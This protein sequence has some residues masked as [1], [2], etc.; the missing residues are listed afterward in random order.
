[1]ISIKRNRIGNFS[2]LILFFCMCCVSQLKAASQNYCATPPFIS[3]QIKPNVLLI[4]DNSGSMKY[5]AYWSEGVDLD[6]VDPY[7]DPQTTYYGIFD[8]TKRYSYNRYDNYF[9]ESSSGDW[10]GNF[11]NWLTMRR[12]DIL[13]KILIGGNYKVDSNGNQFIQGLNTLEEDIYIKHYAFQKSSNLSGYFPSAYIG[14]I[15]TVGLDR[16]GISYYKLD[17]NDRFWFR[18]KNRK[19]G[20]YDWYAIR[21]K[22]DAQPT[23]ILQEISNGQLRLG[24][25]VFN[26]GNRYEDYKYYERDGGYVV[27]YISDNNTD[28]AQL[29]LNQDVY[30]S[31]YASTPPL[32]P[33]NWTP[34][35]ETLYEAVR[36][37]QAR[38]SAYNDVDY[39]NYDPIQFWCQ[40][41]FVI[42]I[43]DGESTKDQNLPHSCFGGFDPTFDYSF[44]IKDWMDKIADN[45]GYY[46]QWCSSLSDDGSYYLEGVAYY[47]HVADIR[48]DLPNKQNLTVFTIY[49]FGKSSKARDMLS[50]AAKYGGFSD[51]NNNDIP[52]VQSEWDSNGDGIPDNYFSAG[53]AEELKDALNQVINMILSQTSSGTSISVLS[54]KTE[55]GANLIQAVFHPNKIF[56]SGD[57]VSW[58]GFLNNFWLIR[59]ETPEAVSLREDTDEDKALSLYDDWIMEF[60]NINNQLIV[61]LYHD[62]DENGICDNQDVNGTCIPDAQKNLDETNKIWESGELLHQTLPDER[63]IWVDVDINGDNVI[64][65]TDAFKESNYAKLETYLE[66]ANDTQAQQIIAYIRGEEVY[67]ARSRLVDGKVWKLSDIIYSTPQVVDYDDYSVVYVGAND[68]MLHAFRLGKLTSTGLTGDHITKLCDSSA[69]T[70]TTTEVG[71]EIWSFIPRNSLP[72]L[73]YLMDN[74]Y[75]HLYYVDLTP[76]VFEAT[77]GTETRTILIGGMR[78]GGACGCTDTDCIQPPVIYCKDS[79]NN[80]VDCSQAGAIPYCVF[81]DGSVKECDSNNDG[82]YDQGV[83]GLSSYFALDITDPENPKLLWE[84]SNPYLGFSYSGPAVMKIGSTYYVAFGSGPTNYAGESDYP[85]RIFVLKLNPDLTIGNVYTISQIETSTQT[86]PITLNNAFSTR[87]LEGCSCIKKGCLTAILCF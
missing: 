66:A 39:S 84:F 64:D 65:I 34:L 54:E 28:L 71:K 51:S 8:P 74:N 86:T 72:Y 61:N 82:I 20:R 10:S 48:P 83:V 69:A 14:Q 21:I 62:Y 77:V 32:Y 75:C 16:D 60:D 6:E 15:F 30:T 38:F 43:T 29:Y 80:I 44:D 78:L 68:G 55:K 5:P 53:S 67:G 81:E 47:A 63:T 12:Y 73:K 3:S 4:V 17:R 11:L 41:N 46:S 59:G 25:M 33:H 24:L 9:F 85:L 50:K 45:E 19:T 37:F 49:T 2:L 22:V 79:S 87:F 7:F 42:M 26:H 58:V 27:K 40:K 57:R 70:C 36:Y 31:N 23:G 1:M 18:V 13:L 52:D 76:F 35:G 56:P